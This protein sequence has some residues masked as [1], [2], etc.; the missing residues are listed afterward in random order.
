M[1]PSTSGSALLEEPL[2][3]TRRGSIF[4]RRRRSRRTSSLDAPRA[5]SAQ[6]E[7]VKRAGRGALRRASRPEFGPIAER[8]RAP[9]S[10]VAVGAQR[11]PRRR[12]RASSSSAPRSA[13]TAACSRATTNFLRLFPNRAARRRSTSAWCALAARR[14]DPQRVRDA[15]RARAAAATCSC[16]PR[17]EFIAR[18][19]RLLGR[20][21][22]DRLR[23]HLRRRSSASWSA[24]IIVYQ[25]LFADV[26]DHLA[27]YAT[28][29]AMGYSN[30]LPLGR[31]APAGGD[32]GRARLRAGRSR[33]ALWLYRIAGAATRL[34][35]EHD[36]RSAALGG[37]RAHGRDVRGLRR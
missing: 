12:R 8:A 33:S 9:A 21:H 18:G 15:I 25:I 23:V 36:A 5:C 29:K 14:S 3:T 20:H 32:P 30:A 13:S 1:S 27:E 19:A 31:G 37:A 6:L 4:V 22:A 10:R 35:L 2:D 7:R 26:S 24:A 28:L 34:P 17:A 11:P 16:S